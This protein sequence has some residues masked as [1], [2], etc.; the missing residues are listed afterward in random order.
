MGYRFLKYKGL[1]IFFFIWVQ[2]T[3]WV[4]WMSRAWFLVHGLFYRF[5]R[6]GDDFFYRSVIRRLRLLPLRHCCFRA[7]CFVCVCSRSHTIRQEC[8]FTS[9]SI[10]LCGHLVGSDLRTS[11]EFSRDVYFTRYMIFLTVLSAISCHQLETNSESKLLLRCNR[12]S[13][14]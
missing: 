4:W 14:T 9:D 7:R 3:T 11:E 2:S 10:A 5:K 13:N 6:V 12:R 1:S 8:L